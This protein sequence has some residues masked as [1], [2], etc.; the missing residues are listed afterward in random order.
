MARYQ[1]F[2]DATERFTREFLHA[3]DTVVTSL[4]EA[5]AYQSLIT[6]RW[7][8]SQPRVA[9]FDHDWPGDMVTA[10]SGRALLQRRTRVRYQSPAYTAV[11]GFPAYATTHIG[12]MRLRL[13]AGEVERMDEPVDRPSLALQ[14]PRR[15]S[16]R[17]VVLPAE[18]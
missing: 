17:L 12:C 18:R 5:F 1:Q 15:S 11:P 8:Q 16:R 13:D 7:R 6:P 2:L 4:D 9:E 10:G 14:V 3:H